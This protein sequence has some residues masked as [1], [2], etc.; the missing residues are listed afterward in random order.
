VQQCSSPTVMEDSIICLNTN[1]NLIPTASLHILLLSDATVLGFMATSKAQTC[2]A[3]PSITVGLLHNG[4]VGLL[5]CCMK[6]KSS[7]V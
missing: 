7:K 6:F 2:I 1:T 5:H 3:E 4:T